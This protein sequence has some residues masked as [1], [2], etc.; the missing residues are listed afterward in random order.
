[1]NGCAGEPKE[2]GN[3]CKA[4]TQC[5]AGVE[6]TL[7][8]KQGGGHDAGDPNLGWDMMKKHPMP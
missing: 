7:C 4:Y 8:T 5:N 1:L 3:G 2:T 6:V